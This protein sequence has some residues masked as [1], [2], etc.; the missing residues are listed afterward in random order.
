[1]RAHH[2]DGRAALPR[3][4][5][6]RVRHVDLVRHGLRLRGQPEQSEPTRLRRRPRSRR[7]HSGGDRPL[8]PSPDPG[9]ANPPRWCRVDRS[10]SPPAQAPRPSP[11]QPDARRRARRRAERR[12][13]KPPNR[14]RRSGPVPPASA[15]PRR[16]YI[17]P[18]P[19]TSHR[20]ARRCEKLSC[21]ARFATAMPLR[22]AF[23]A[24]GRS[25]SATM[26]A[27]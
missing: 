22:R 23:K 1:M 25:S 8:R 4:V 21:R 12:P 2:D 15:M 27:V 11:A 10:V 3:D 5:D 17:D 19:R 9:A 16:A 26:A 24:D 14:R 18:S 13:G 20:R 6:Q 7:A